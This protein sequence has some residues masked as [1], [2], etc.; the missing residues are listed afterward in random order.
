MAALLTETNIFSNMPTGH[1]GLRD[2]GYHR[3]SAS[4]EAPG[5]GNIP[6]IAWRRLAEQHAIEVI[7]SLCANARPAGTT[8][9][10]V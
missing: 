7:E 5:W 2:T 3:N 9:P 10:A 6:L 1:A 8:V 4:R